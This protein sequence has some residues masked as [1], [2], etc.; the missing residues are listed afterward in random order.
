[1]QA[2]V[3][4]A[5][6]SFRHDHITTVYAEAQRHPRVRIVAACEPDPSTRQRVGIAGLIADP[7]D[8]WLAAEQADAIIIGDIYDRRGS[9]VAEALRRGKHVLGDK[10][11]CTRLDELDEI[12]TLARERHLTVS[13]LLGNPFRASFATL[14]RRLADG[15]IGRPHQVMFSGQHPLLYGKRPMWYFERGR[16]GGTINDIAVHATHLIPWLT[17]CAIAEVL[18]ARTWNAFAPH[19]PHFHDAGQLMLRLDNDAGVIGDVSYAMP[20]DHGYNLPQYWRITVFGSEGVA[21]TAQRS[22]CVFIARQGRRDPERIAVTPPACSLLDRWVNY[23]TTGEGEPIDT[24]A[25]L[26][27]SRWALLAQQLAD[28]ER[29]A[30]LPRRASH[31][32]AALNPQEHRYAW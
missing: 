27:A 10:P 3:R 28:R 15:A 4:V 29:P 21:E 24:S 6:C 1:M 8:F 14:A 17:G 13:C 9:L 30:T 2:P 11:L 31:A 16:H 25:V 19:T 20:D 26:R 32:H 23:L 12:Q 18:A 7:A 22:D 5:F